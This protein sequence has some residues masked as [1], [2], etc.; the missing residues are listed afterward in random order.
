MNDPRKLNTERSGRRWAE[1]YPWLGTGPISPKVCTS[2]EYYAREIETIYKKLWLKVARDE[3]LPTPGDY[4]VRKLHFANTSVILMRGNDGRVRAFHNTCMHRGNTVVMADAARYE[5]RGHTNG[6]NIHCHFHG[7]V[8]DD[9]GRLSHVPEREKFYDSFDAPNM[10]LRTVPCETWNGFIFINLDTN[11]AQNL[12]DFLGGIGRHFDG[13]DYASCTRVYSYNTLMET[14]WKV[15]IDA[16]SEAYHVYT[17][18]G[19]SFPVRPDEARIEDIEF[20]GPHRTSTICIDGIA[21]EP[22]PMQTLSYRLAN[23]SI[24]D[25]SRGASMLPPQINPRR[26]PGFAF[27]LSCLFPNFLLH[28]SEGFYFT[29]QFWPVAHNRV[30]WEG[31]YYL[32]PPKTN[33]ERWAQEYSQVLQ[34]NAW[35]EDTETMENT[36]RSLES[37]VLQAIQLQDDEAL[38]RHSYW[39]TDEFVN[40]RPVRA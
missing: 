25:N 20:F 36:H 40:N 32:V 5:T 8:Y 39:V 23:S 33:S 11:P 6:A 10:G 9:H 31:H 16:F 17:I 19:G 13:F 34:R 21:V 38:L 3:E 22:G 12:T 26:D 29:H 18:H 30:L 2:P 27:E 1:K 35:L 24:M 14:D 15:A 4:K 37:G 7:W 28:I